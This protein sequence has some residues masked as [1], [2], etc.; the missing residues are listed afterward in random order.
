MS[1]Q[2]TPNPHLHTFCV[3]NF[4]GHQTSNDDDTHNDGHMEQC[5]RQWQAALNNLDLELKAKL[6]GV[7][8]NRASILALLSREAETKKIMCLQR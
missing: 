5:K 1:V 4:S 2:P 3:S 6:G 7:G 8:G